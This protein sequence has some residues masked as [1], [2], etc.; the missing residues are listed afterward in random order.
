MKIS[1]AEN[2]TLLYPGMD[3]SFFFIQ[4]LPNK[5]PVQRIPGFFLG[6]KTAEASS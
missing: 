3:K 5:L 2:R 4:N 1:V 6:C